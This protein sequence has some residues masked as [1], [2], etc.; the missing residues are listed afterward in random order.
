MTETKHIPTSPT[1]AHL[2]LGRFGETYA[3]RRLVADGLVLLE[4][5]WRGSRGEV[6]LILREGSTLV[7]CEVKTRTGQ[8]HG[9]A[10]EAVD[11][12]KLTRLQALAEEWMEARGVR[13]VE[14]RFDVVAV[15]VD[16]GAVTEFEHIQG[17]G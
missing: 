15:V 12:A 5:N 1:A 6:D 16:R 14:V 9:H 8:A 4:R 13:P 11:A 7:L 3:A 2:V 17:V 10:M